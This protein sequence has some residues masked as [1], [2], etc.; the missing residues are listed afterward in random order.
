[1]VAISHLTIINLGDYPLTQ[2]IKGIEM[3]NALAKNPPKLELKRY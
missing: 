3:R 2:V 1:M